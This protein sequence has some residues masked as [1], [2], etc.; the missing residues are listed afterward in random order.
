MHLKRP[1][2]R[3]GGR[4]VGSQQNFAGQ[5]RQY[6]LTRKTYLLT[7]AFEICAGVGV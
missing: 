2:K 4:M 5:A 7:W 1:L 6:R 3:S